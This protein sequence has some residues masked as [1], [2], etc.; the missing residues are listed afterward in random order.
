MAV[1]LE[2]FQSQR[3]LG[4]VNAKVSLS[5]GVLLFEGG[6][7]F[8]SL[9]KRPFTCHI[10]TARLIFSKSKKSLSAL[11]HHLAPIGNEGWSQNMISFLIKQLKGVK[12]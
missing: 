4:T 12:M 9:V 1:Q 10:Y 11:I 8:A 7:H 2:T 5:T 3:L 6:E